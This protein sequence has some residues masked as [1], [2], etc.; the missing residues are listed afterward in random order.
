MQPTPY[1]DVN[2]LLEG[3]LAGIQTILHERLAGLYLFGSL[4]AGDFDPGVSDVDLLAATTSNITCREFEGLRVMH[5]DIVR[6]SP[7]WDDRI[8][9]LYFSL[10]GL[11]TFR[12]ETSP[13]TVISPGE[14]LN[15][16]EADWGWLMNWY[17]VREHGK[18]LFGPPA[19]AIIAPIK[20]E[21]F[22][23]TVRSYVGWLSGSLEEAR[24]HRKKQSYLVLTMCR[25]LYTHRHG[26]QASKRQAARWA[27]GELP[28]WA[29]LIEDALEWREAGRD[30]RG[31]GTATYADTV[32]FV[33]FVR[34]QLRAE[35]G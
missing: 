11:R 9:V 13:I 22:V 12:T 3:L 26:E 10:K 4:T 24:G 15:T 28:E 32:R 31:D 8:E 27:Q 14:P 5:R 29:G 18:A 20:R 19:S 1:P 35:G 21:E 17:A 2:R 16:K 23:Q 6:E 34:D 30:A 33:N 25:A 7:E